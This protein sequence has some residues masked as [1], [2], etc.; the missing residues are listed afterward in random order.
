[1]WSA[2]LPA[3]TAKWPANMPVLQF[4]TVS[5]EVLKETTQL[6]FLDKLKLQELRAGGDLITHLLMGA[7]RPLLR[8]NFMLATT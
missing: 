8:R 2:P 7:R 4:L 5:N 1:M 3:M 6:N